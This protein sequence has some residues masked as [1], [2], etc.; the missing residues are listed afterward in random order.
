MP[1]VRRTQTLSVN[2][3][4]C[5]GRITTVIVLPIKKISELSKIKCKYSTT[6]FIRINWVD[7]PSG[8]ADKTGNCIFI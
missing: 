8:Y 1:F 6:S 2:K 3:A 4:T 5:F 7:E